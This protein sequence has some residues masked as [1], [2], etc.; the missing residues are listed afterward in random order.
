MGFGHSRPYVTSTLRCNRRDEEGSCERFQFSTTREYCVGFCFQFNSVKNLVSSRRTV[1]MMSPTNIPQSHQP[2]LFPQTIQTSQCEPVVQV[3]GYQVDARTQ[4]VPPDQPA[5][6]HSGS[7]PVLAQGTSVMAVMQL[8]VSVPSGAA[9]GQEVHFTAPDGRRLSAKVPEGVA[10]GSVLTVQY[11]INHQPPVTAQ[12]TSQLPPVAV[13]MEDQDAQASSWGWRMY[14]AGWLC[15]FCNVWCGFLLWLAAASLYYCKPRS[16]R[17]NFPRQR[18][19]AAASLITSTTLAVFGMFMLMMGLAV[20]AQCGEEF[21]RCPGIA[22]RIQHMQKAT[23]RWSDHMDDE[24]QRYFQPQRHSS[25]KSDMP[26][27]ALGQQEV[28]SHV[29]SG[30]LHKAHEEHFKQPELVT[31]PLPLV[32]EHQDLIV[33]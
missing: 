7:P 5:Q 3:N 9:P 29:W 22:A 25:N 21:Q 19:P 4:L 20:F 28:P 27:L 11:P 13:S 1:A 33:D 2:S 23:N 16:A 15:L 18:G 17:R 31:Q 12:A 10:P 14:A 6:P 24:F 26:A 32:S 30:F 8:Q